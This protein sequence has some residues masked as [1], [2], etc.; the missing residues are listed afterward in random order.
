MEFIYTVQNGVH[1][2]RTKW[3]RRSEIAEFMLNVSEF[4]NL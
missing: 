4:E 2:H 1:I 3:S